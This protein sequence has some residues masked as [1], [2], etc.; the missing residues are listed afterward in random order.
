MK[1]MALLTLAAIVVA[2]CT[3]P[4][5]TV[6]TVAPT[7]TA[8]AAQISEQE[9]LALADKFYDLSAVQQDYAGAYALFDDQMK[10]AITE[11]KLYSERAGF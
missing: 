11:S 10:A 7:A 3:G 6:T 2:G 1:K 8:A 5:V 4:A 9:A